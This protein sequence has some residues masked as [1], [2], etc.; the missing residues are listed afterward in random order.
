LDDINVWAPTIHLFKG[1]GMRNLQY[2]MRICQKSLK[3]SQKL[4]LYTNFL[5]H[6]F[7]GSKYTLLGKV[8]T[9]KVVKN[10]LG[11]PRSRHNNE[12]KSIIQKI[13]PF[14]KA[15]SSLGCVAKANMHNGIK[16]FL[17]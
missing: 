14:Q 10:R 1:L 16:S 12:R 8:L 7:L 4:I 17:E 13:H 15:D 6:T 11:C 2:E 5:I 3:K 9:K